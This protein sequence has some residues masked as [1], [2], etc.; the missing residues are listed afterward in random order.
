MSH[1]LVLSAGAVALLRNF[2]GQLVVLHD[3]AP[4]DDPA[5]QRLYPSTTADP[6]LDRDLRDL[7]HP[8][9]V[10]GRLEAFEV[11]GAVL[12]DADGSGRER[13]LEFD[14]DQ[15]VAF[16]GVVN[17][18]RLALAARINLPAL[19]DDDGELPDDLPDQTLAVAELVSWLALLQD[20]V[21]ASL[22]PESMDHQ[23]D[24][25]RAGL[26]EDLAGGADDLD[27]LPDGI[28]PNDDTSDDDATRAGKSD[29]AVPGDDD[30]SDDEADGDPPGPGA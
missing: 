9:L 1:R 30:G 20:Q 18:V 19:V 5:W 6:R 24:L 16:L 2:V 21:L 4:T 17:D 29:D 10:E 23:R 13:T 12:A 3:E 28:V 27:D 22:A 8:D 11:V 14:D 26:A 25:V 15:A 7:V